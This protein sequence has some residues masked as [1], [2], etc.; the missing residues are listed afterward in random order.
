VETVARVKAINAEKSKLE[1]SDPKTKAS[2][3]E[4][5]LIPSVVQELKRH[6][7]RQVEERLFWGQAYNKENLVFPT[8]FGTPLEPQNFY[9]KHCSIIRKTGINIS[10]CMT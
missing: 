3:R 1:F 4:I 5:P 8:N 9:R 7:A 6:K 10:G 2:I